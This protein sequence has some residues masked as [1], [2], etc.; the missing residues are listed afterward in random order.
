MLIAPE[1]GAGG[2][3]E[4]RSIVGVSREG[5]GIRMMILSPIASSVPAAAASSLRLAPDTAGTLR[6]S[7]LMLGGVLVSVALVAAVALVAITTVLGR[8]ARRVAIAESQLRASL[9]AEVSFLA[10]ARASDRA[11]SE[12]SPAASAARSNA[13]HELRFAL[14]ET[15]RFMTP[16]RLAELDSVAAA[17]VATRKRLEEGGLPLGSVIESST[18]WAVSSDSSLRIARQC[19]LPSYPPDTGRPPRTSSESA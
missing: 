13:E 15:R 11:A 16:I 9:R 3:K 10:Y 4:A 1:T 5:E 8:E 19:A 2:N 18:P 14:A 6:R 12:R 7:M 17:Y